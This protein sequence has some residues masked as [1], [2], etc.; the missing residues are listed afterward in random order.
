[1]P[2]SVLGLPVHPLVVHAAVVL[3][4]LSSILTIVIAASPDRRARLGWLVWLL[5]SGGLVSCF[6]AISSGEVLQSELYPD[7]VPVAVTNHESFGRTVLW[8]AAALWLSVTALLLL[9]LNRRR[10][11]GVGSPVLPTV[12]AVVAILAAMAATGQVLVTGWTGTENRWSGVVQS[13]EGADH[14]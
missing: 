4:P 10:H 14:A 7:G 2:E 8:F 12:V 5:S 1:M 6:V 11:T 3:I 13:L 9:D